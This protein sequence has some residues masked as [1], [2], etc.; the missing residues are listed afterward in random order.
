MARG[1]WRGICDNLE[2]WAAMSPL[3]HRRENNRTKALN[4]N[5]SSS[6]TIALL[7]SVV[8][9]PDFSMASE[10]SVRR[11]FGMDAPGNDRG[12]WIRHVGTVNDCENICLADPGCAGYTYN[13]RRSTCIPKNRIGQLILHGETP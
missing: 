9:P 6:V 5:F 7:L 8:M 2:S 10:P 3:V 11:H 4:H 13:A 1:S 12:M